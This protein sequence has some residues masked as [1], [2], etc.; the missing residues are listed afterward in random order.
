MPTFWILLAILCAI[1]LA[2]IW[3]PLW[4]NKQ[5][6]RCQQLKQ[7]QNTLYRE[8]L[9]LLNQQV[10][11]NT[12]SQHEF[13]ALKSELDTHLLTTHHQLKHRPYA[14]WSPQRQRHF[15]V[16]L[17]C[18][19]LIMGGGIYQATGHFHQY[20]ATGVKRSE[21]LS[22]NVQRVIDMIDTIKQ[23]T[24]ADPQDQQAWQ[25]LADVYMN[26]EIYEHAVSVY[27]K[28]IKLATD[29]DR[30]YGQ[31]ATANYFLNQRHLTPKIQTLIE[32]A[33]ALNPTSPSALLL[34]AVHH[35]TQQNYASAI[36]YWQQLLTLDDPQINKKMISQAIGDA[37]QQHLLSQQGRVELTID[38]KPGLLQK[39]R[40]TDTLFIAARPMGQSLPVAVRKLPIPQWPLKT[41]ISD[42]HAMNTTAKMS[43]F[44]NINISVIVSHSGRMPAVKDDLIGSLTEV[45]VEGQ[46]KYK[47]VIDRL[48]P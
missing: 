15:S 35:Y 8:R 11:Q 34:L 18:V 37:K 48:R 3:M 5:L 24:E 46:P 14:A 4:S 23:R 29:N 38:I 20:E 44:K 42:Q 13:E 31:L 7:S 36:A 40:A 2:W 39:V 17:S 6:N 43:E 32:Q 9:G 41:Y 21:P 47:I 33:L 30:Y 25:Q 19:F 27:E 28:L 1:G 16:V 22:P 26:F 10:Q 12:L 45:T